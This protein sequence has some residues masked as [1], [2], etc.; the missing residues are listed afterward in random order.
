[1]K[2]AYKYRIYPNFSQR[3]ALAKIFGFCR[4]LY[5][6][7]LEERISFY[8]KF[9][10][11]L[12]YYD[13][14]KSLKEIKNIF[15]CETENIHSQTLQQVLK[16]LDTSFKNFFRRIKNKKIAPGF[17]RFKNTDRFRGIL[18]PQCDLNSGGA[19]RLPNS[20][21]KIKGVPG[22]IK[23]VWHRP[24]QGRCKQV[25]IVKNND[26][27]FI[28]LF[29][30]DVPNIETR[31]LTGKTVA[32]DLGIS[33][34]IT[35]DDGLKIHHPKPYKT[36]KEKLKYL[37]RRAAKQRGSNN[38]HRMRI[39]IANQF[40]KIVNIRNE[41]QHKTVN[42][43]IKNY[44]VITIEKLNIKKMLEN[45]NFAV[46]KINISEVSWGNFINILKYKAENAGVLIKEVNPANT[47]QTCS[48]CGKLRKIKLDL[49]DR[50][51]KCEFCNFEMDRD[52][53][54]ALNIK[55]LGTSFVTMAASPP[56]SEAHAF[57]RG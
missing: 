40:E 39:R 18:F 23:A 36:A 28:I 45:I 17:P 31:E 48:Q 52:Q 11:S 26:K 57:R 29:C 6:S 38:S 43:L 22:E 32:I 42:F 4:F 12:N 37:Q 44:D 3:E 35:T 5:N 13:Q 25:R 56:V 19:K 55:K 16:Q 51:F 49:K 53:N 50:I 41:F 24:F 14:E 7:A 21:L 20:K 15:G 34:F 9:K 1:M 27:Y 54:A 10:K 47:S 2:R 46:S 8:K 33:N 30:D